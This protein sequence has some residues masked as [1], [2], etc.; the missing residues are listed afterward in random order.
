M[1]QRTFE[2]PAENPLPDGFWPGEPIEAASRSELD[3]LLADA[4]AV[5]D[6]IGGTFSVV[7]LRQELI[8][9]NHQ[10]TGLYV[11]IG[12]RA[13]WESFAPAQRAQPVS[14]PVEAPEPAAVVEPEPDAEPEPEEA[15]ELGSED[16]FGMD[17]EAALA[18]A[19]G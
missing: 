13:K 15:Q 10:P 16:D 18:A 14:T 3:E 1:P 12:Y 7:A 17:A 5:L 6:R 19:E 4:A 8:D 2:V 9:A 11:T